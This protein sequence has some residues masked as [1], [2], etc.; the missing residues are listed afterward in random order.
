MLKEIIIIFTVFA[1]V[2]SLDI[3]TNNYTTYAT[4]SLSEQFAELREYI[5][6]KDIENLNKKIQEIDNN[7]NKYN[8]KLSYYMEH[9][10]LEKVGNSLSALKAHNEVE[11]YN[12]S[13]ED[14][15]EN[16]FILQ[17]I[18]E[19]ERFSISSLF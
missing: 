9:D 17:H 8:K 7:W 12:D 13:I 18:Q 5:I 16:I 15:D 1:I 14:I 3:I 19:K 4:D 10:E 11:E 6:K 2:I